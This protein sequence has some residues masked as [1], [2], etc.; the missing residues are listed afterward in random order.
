MSQYAKRCC[1]PHPDGFLAFTSK[2]MARWSPDELPCVLHKH[3]SYIFGSAGTMQVLS[4][5]MRDHIQNVPLTVGGFI[6]E[7]SHS[8]V[9]ECLGKTLHVQLC[10][11]V[12]N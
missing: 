1:F 9:A 4:L 12:Q 5:T 10:W 3:G 7:L 11:D 8:T 6:D 2:L